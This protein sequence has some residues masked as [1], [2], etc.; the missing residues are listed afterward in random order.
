MRHSGSWGLIMSN[1]TQIKRRN[2]DSLYQAFLLGWSLFEEGAPRHS[3]PTGEAL[4]KPGQRNGM[5]RALKAACVAGWW[6]AGVE[7]KNCE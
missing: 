7:E 4:L 2:A 3:L 5:S 6:L 1:Q